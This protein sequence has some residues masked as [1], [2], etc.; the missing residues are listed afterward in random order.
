MNRVR[1][2]VTRRCWISLGSNLEREASIRGGVRGLRQAFGPLILSPVYETEAVGFDGSP[3]L[4][5]VAGIESALRVSEIRALLRRIEAEH[6]RERSGELEGE[7][8]AERT[9]KRTG[10]RTSE[11]AGE[12]AG[13]RT[14]ERFAPR[15]LDL[16]LLTYGELAG[17]IDGYRLPRDEILRYA[18]VLGPLADVAPDERH[19]IDG[20][21]YAELWQQLLA[22]LRDAHQAQL[23]TAPLPASAGKSGSGW[24]PL[25]RIELAIGAT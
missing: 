18:F 23:D 19:P 17:E 21:R 4:N 7:R 13:E 24:S 11:Q 16:D 12:Q 8:A 20:R 2:P 15:T 14:S 25:R 9:D 22:Q 10:V 1:F 6:G 5:L 3:F